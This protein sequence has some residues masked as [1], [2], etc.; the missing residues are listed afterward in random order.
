MGASPSEAWRNA[1]M[2][3]LRLLAGHGRATR[4]LGAEDGSAPAPS[5]EIMGRALFEAIFP[6][7]LRGLYDA[8]HRRAA[9]H[10]QALRLRLNVRV[11]SLALLPWELLCDAREGKHI[12]L[13]SSLAVV[14]S[15]EHH[16]DLT[17][18]GVAPPLR[19]LAVAASPRDLPPLDL[20]RERRLLAEAAA[21]LEAQGRLVL[22]WL[23]DISAEQLEQEL[24]GGPYH[25][26]HFAGHGHFDRGRDRGF[27]AL[28]RPDG[29]SDRIPTESLGVLLSNARVQLA[30]L[31]CCEGA[32][33]SRTGV[34]SSMAAKLLKMG[35]PSVV[36]MQRAVP[37][38]TAIAFA[39]A[40]YGALCEGLTVEAALHRARVRLSLADPETG[41]W[42]IPALYTRALDGPL[43]EVE[44]PS[45]LRRPPVS[46]AQE[47]IAL[48]PPPPPAPLPGRPY[49]VLEPYSHP[50][51][52]KGREVELSSTL[53]DLA[54]RRLILCMYGAS[55]SGKSSGGG[56]VR[57]PWGG[58][59]AQ[60]GST[61][62]HACPRRRRL[63]ATLSSSVLMIR[64][65]S[66]SPWNDQESTTASHRLSRSASIAL[67]TLS[68][69]PVSIG[70]C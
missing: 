6:T 20:E 47:P 16:T 1:P 66:S 15:P 12:A 19:L 11:P 31:N 28:S 42:A 68:S 39:A 35:V 48:V 3:G 70:A 60:V 25:V 21:P 45:S 40:F 59:S 64:R 58:S 5:V 18:V 13:S 62:P 50:D 26:F 8:A 44:D 51:T 24:R 33:G 69:S 7:D 34:F 63:T 30:V 9:N 10:G 14:R 56:V 37:D 27:L 2:W 4:D 52:F 53:R 67:A 17:P 54:N 32:T 38:T 43:V 57:S 41:E 55:G 29:R 49:P 65:T 36:A 23:Q 46:A 22:K 61:T